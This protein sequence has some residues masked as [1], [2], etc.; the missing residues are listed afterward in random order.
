VKVLCGILA[1]TLSGQALAAPFVGT[2]CQQP[3]F[4]LT[5]GTPAPCTGFLFSPEKEQ[6]LRLE[7]Q[8]YKLLK[9]ESD[10]KDK[11]LQLYKGEVND[12]QIAVSKEKDETKMWRD[13]ADATEQK[14]ITQQ[15][16][17]GFRD[18]LFT[19]LGVLLTVGAGYAI[20]KASHAAGTVKK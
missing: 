11:Q 9:D 1:I 18:I 5:A 15:E 8:D 6:E 17:A 19:V 14:Y 7:D 12:L 20:G 2:S 4:A 16:R 10:L 13:T 3:V